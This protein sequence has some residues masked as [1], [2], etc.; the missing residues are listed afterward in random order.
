[1]SWWEGAVA[2]FHWRDTACLGGKA[3]WQQ[4]EAAGHCIPSQGAERHECQCSPSFP[5]L[6]QSRIPAHGTVLSSFGVHLPSLINTVWK[7]LHSHGQGFAS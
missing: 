3:L 6:I 4:C 1:M 7:L 2:P 5:L